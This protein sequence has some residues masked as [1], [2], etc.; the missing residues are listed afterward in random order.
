MCVC[1]CLCVARGEIARGGA[2]CSSL[3]CHFLS[4]VVCC[5][6]VC[7]FGTVECWGGR[8]GGCG[9]ELC[10]RQ[11]RVCGSHAGCVSCELVCVCVSFVRVVIIC[12]ASTHTALVSSPSLAVLHL[13]TYLPPSRGGVL[14][15]RGNPVRGANPR[16]PVFTLR[17]FPCERAPPGLG[18]SCPQPDP[19]HPARWV[20]F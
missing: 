16:R 11:L 19:D 3:A 9:L 20:R 1:V 4:S 18:L 7:S 17:P 10:V 13:S 5:A 6:L 8:Q 14:Q 15:L 2:S 12:L